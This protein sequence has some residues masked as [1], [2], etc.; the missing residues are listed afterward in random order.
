MKKI[1]CSLL[2]AL[3]AALYF[4]CAPEEDNI[5]NDSSANR[6]D[7]ALK[8]TSEILTGAAN[9][10]LMQYY[11]SSTQQYGGYNMLVSFSTDGYVTV[12]SEVDDS[13]LTVTSTYTLK[14]SAGPVLSF[15][16]YNALFH[17]FSDPKNPAGIGTNGK[18]MEGDLEFVIMEAGKDKVVLQG[19]KTRN[20]IEMTP[21][22][23]TVSWKE[24]IDA[25]VEADERMSFAACKYV[26]GDVSGSVS[27][28]YRNMSITYQDGE[29][30]VTVKAP[31]IVTET[32]YKLYKSLELG[33][34]VVDEFIYSSSGDSFEFTSSDGKAKLLPVPINQQ[35][36][37]GSWYFT[38][39]R[40]G[41]FGAPY[42]NTIKANY[43]A[44]TGGEQ[45][46]YAYLGTQTG[47]GF[48]FASVIGSTAYRG[49]IN[50]TYEL[51]GEDQVKFTYATYDG[52]G[53]WY[54]QNAYFNYL[55]HP[56]SPNTKDAFRI[57]TLTTNSMSNP[58]WIKLQDVDIPENS[59]TLYRQTTYYPFNN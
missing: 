36:V 8:A 30:S 48:C 51:I 10:W 41:S 45:L 57:F 27:L 29:N 33:G 24:Y 18:G 46:Y 53:G 56:I 35:F 13:D 34:A 52:N 2:I 11:P 31:F 59:F 16:T 12:S 7:A 28:S 58:A 17:F 39:S 4:S 38:L 5:F 6:I 49:T 32:G 15:D 37:A 44:L 3:S 47:Y 50:Y 19:R 40:M 43:S 25:L 21:L 14:Q 20:R 42:W 1:I 26:A 22:A 9:G 55:I 23:A 54:L